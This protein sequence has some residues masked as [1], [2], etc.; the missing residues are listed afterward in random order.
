M[1]F[2]VSLLLRVVE[3]CKTFQTSVREMSEVYFSRL[4]RHNYVTPTS[5]LELILTFKNLLG[6]KRDEVNTARNRYLVGLEKLE[7]AASQMMVKIESETVE[8]DMIED[9]WGPSKKLLSDLKFLDNLKSYDKDNISPLYIKKIREKFI[10]HADFQPS[11]IKNVSSACEGLCKWVRA[12]EVYERVIKVVAPKRERLKLAENELAIQMDML[13]VK[14]AEL[15]KVEDRLQSLNDDL[16]AM[17][18]KKKDLE[19]NIELCS[20][21]LIRAEKLIGGLGGEKDRWTEAARQL[22]DILLSSG[23]VSYLGAFTVDYRIDC[24]EQWHKLCQEK[25]IPCSEDFALTS[26]LGN[27]VAIRAWQIA[28]LPVDSFSTDNG[29]IVF[30]SRRWPLMIDPQGQANKWVKNMEKANNL[31]VIKQSDGNYV[32]ILENCIHYPSDKFPVS[33]L[34]NGL[35][36]TN[37]PPKGIRANLL[38]S[39]LSDPISDA[40]FFYSS[41]KQAIWQKLL[42]GLTFFHALV[43]ERRNFGPLGKKRKKNQK[44]LKQLFFPLVFNFSKLKYLFKTR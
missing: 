36:M 42:F 12:M 17:I 30:N 21:K 25:K 14:R 6:I 28:G 10:E 37:E 7:F 34:Q 19:D 31:S 38:R 23:T 27:Q 22:G 1:T 15:K 44:M 8:V 24:Q 40:D 18:N 41:K 9:Y 35:K 39:Y 3:M 20:Q 2:V 32:R 4:R 33:I 5:Y 13:A 43:Q 26:T 11:V 16:D 29:I